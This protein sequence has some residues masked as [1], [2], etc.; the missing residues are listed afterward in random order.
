LQK[1]SNALSFLTLILLVNLALDHDVSELMAA[2][3]REFDDALSS[4]EPFDV[5]AA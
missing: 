5:P 1:N 2:I 3:R 4:L